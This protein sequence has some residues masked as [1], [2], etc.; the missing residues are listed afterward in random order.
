MYTGI[1]HSYKKEWSSN[2]TWM[3]LED[4]MLS[5]IIQTQNR[6]YCMII[7]KWGALKCHIHQERKQSTDNQALEGGGIEESVF[8]YRVSACDG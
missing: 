3:K 1:L 4:I 7:L 2:T 6:K 8:K 5:G